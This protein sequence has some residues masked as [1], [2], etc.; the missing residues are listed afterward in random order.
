M[1]QEGQCLLVTTN[2]VKTNLEDVEKYPH[3]G[4]NIPAQS[5]F[6]FLRFSGND[7][8]LTSHKPQA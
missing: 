3:V 7:S 4:I 5:L 6:A 2:S 8:E 1:V